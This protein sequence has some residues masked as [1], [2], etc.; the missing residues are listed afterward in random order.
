MVF[1]LRNSLRTKLINDD[2]EE[3]QFVFIEK[4]SEEI[5]S[6]DFCW[7][8]PL[9][10][11]SWLE[12]LNC[13]VF[14][15]LSIYQQGVSMD[16]KIFEGHRIVDGFRRWGLD[17][18]HETTFWRSI[19]IIIIL[20]KKKDSKVFTSFVFNQCI[21]YCISTT[22]LTALYLKGNKPMSK[23]NYLFMVFSNCILYSNWI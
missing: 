10:F 16:N 17:F 19:E 20:K 13:S 7:D 2:R 6:W 5:F 21:S 22:Y 18:F 14:A 1:T 4:L 3:H 9:V 15:T 8:I 12:H 23:Y 11:I